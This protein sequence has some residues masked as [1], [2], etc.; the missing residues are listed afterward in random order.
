MEDCT[1]LQIPCVRNQVHELCRK[2]ATIYSTILRAFSQIVLL[3]Y[4]LGTAAVTDLAA[5]DP[6]GIVGVVL[7]APFTSGIRL[8]INQPG[9]YMDKFLTVEKVRHIKVPILVCHGCRDDSISVEHGFEVYNRAPRVVSPL[10]LDDADHVSIFNG[11][12]LH[13]FVRIRE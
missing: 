5:S 1:T 6:E 8:F 11:K 4:S 12:Y 7:V 13:T 10:F 2:T 9:R 3:G